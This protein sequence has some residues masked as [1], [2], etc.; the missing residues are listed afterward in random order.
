MHL[1]QFLPRL[2]TGELIGCFGL[3]GTMAHH[4]LVGGRKVEVYEIDTATY[5]LCMLRVT[6]G[7]SYPYFPS[8][9]QSPTMA[10]TPVAWR[11]GPESSLTGTL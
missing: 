8:F 1:L 9:F 11:L 5:C 6:L 3:T 2:A 10:L 4:M 7:F